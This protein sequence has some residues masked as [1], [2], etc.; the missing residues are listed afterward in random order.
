MKKIQLPEQ[1]K[2]EFGAQLYNLLNHPHFRNPSGNLTASSLGI[3]S[4]D[5]SPP[6][7]LYGSGQGAAVSGRVI[8][9]MGKFTF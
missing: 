6:T 8:V 9:V 4:G 2:L 1:M 5:Y 3:I 7:S